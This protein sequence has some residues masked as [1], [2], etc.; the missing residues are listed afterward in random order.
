MPGGQ[1][2]EDKAEES[3]TAHPI[4]QGFSI[5]ILKPYVKAVTLSEKLEWW[6]I[7]KV[8]C[9]TISHSKNIAK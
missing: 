2:G 8:D 1:Q 9:E 7:L 5:I 4:S 3:S 6:I